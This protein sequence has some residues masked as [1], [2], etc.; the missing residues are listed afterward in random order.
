MKAA[1]YQ[2]AQR[3]HPDHAGEQE[4]ARDNFAAIQQAYSCLR[5]VDE[6]KQ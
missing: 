2:L 6:Q 4:V 1:F 3:Y 5:L